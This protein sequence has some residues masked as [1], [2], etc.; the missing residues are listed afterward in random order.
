MLKNYF[1]VA[2]RNL[3]KNKSYVVVNAFGVGIAMAC[4]LTAYLV[5]A[6][7]LEF[8]DFHKDE[9]VNRVFEVH[10]QVSN[11]DG[12]TFINNSA[13][14]T[15]PSVAVPQIAGIER[16]TRYLHESAYLR[17]GDKAFT[18]KVSFADS[19]FFEIFEFP[20]VKGSHKSFKNK[21]TILLSEELARKYF[22]N[23][24][25]VGKMLVIN[26]QNDIE[27]EVIVGGVL[28]KVPINNTFNFGAL[29]R[30]ENFHDIHQFTDG[31]WSDGS[32][33]ST[34]M[35]LSSTD[36]SATIASELNRY[37]PMRNEEKKDAFV[38]D[39]QLEPFKKGFTS[40]DI[41]S[42][43]TTLRTPFAVL[44][45]FT[46]MAAMILLTACFNLTNTTIAMTSRRL[47]EIGIRKTI[48]AFRKQIVSQFLLETIM[49][50]TLSLGVALLLAQW[51]VPAFNSLY[52][53]PF[54]LDDVNGLNLVVT[55]IGLMSFASLVAGIYPALV[56]SGFKPIALLKSSAR[57]KGTNVLTRT[58]L[59]LQFSLSVIV[60]IGGVIFTLNA[61]FQETMNFG[62]DKEMVITISI[63]EQ[64]EFEA[65]ESAVASYSKIVSV[66]VSE[67]HVGQSS[68]E[69]TVQ[70][71]TG[72]HTTQLLGVGKNYF[73]T[74]GLKLHEGRF[75]DV[76]NAS[77]RKEAVIV[78]QAFIDKTGIK[79]PLDEV[80]TVNQTK[81]RIV[82]VV[83]NHIE[84]IF[85]SNTPPSFVASVILLINKEFVIILAIAAF[86]GSIG[87]L[88][89]IDALLNVFN[90]RHVEVGIIP[91]AMCGF[92]IFGIGI[93]TTS[94]TILKAARTSPVHTLRSE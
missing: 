66:S 92:V 36:A 64:K 82:G 27:I 28:K 72:E 63:R 20:L 85:I 73:E 41:N 75:P 14:M 47:K 42:S 2:F 8:D 54:T 6:Y 49:I 16:F 62:Y 30:I 33:P 13:P 65:M 17:Y 50:I 76:A 79:S 23:E 34:Y 84:S 18:E 90:M 44:A 29:M 58:L 22:E 94:F 78:N 69:S 61:K 70:V 35:E 4:C 21:H 91:T 43:Y 86:V 37:I 31:D 45:L 15:L 60:L 67:H 9:K 74:M 81:R 55:L 46:S 12:T 59:A 89:L 40:L 5:I 83:E 38:A 68:Y 10:T 19:T 7:D 25:A 51:I 93:V 39:F 1:L 48:G 11:P 53:V 77:E 87:G 3:L 57:I 32:D 52:N 71:G 26:F 56:N 80:I 88:Y 24:E